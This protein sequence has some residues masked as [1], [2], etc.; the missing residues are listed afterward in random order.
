MGGVVCVD[1]VRLLPDQMPGVWPKEPSGTDRAG[2][3]SL[4]IDA[5]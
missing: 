3:G 1:P 5:R 4:E 2:V